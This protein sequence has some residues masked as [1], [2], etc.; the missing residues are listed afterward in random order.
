MKEIVKEKWLVI[1]IACSVFARVLMALYLGNTVVELPGTADQLSYHNLALRILDGHGFSFAETWW[2]LTGPDEPTAHWS[3]LYTL[4]VTAVYA[5]TGSNPVVAR[6]LQ[7]IIVGVLHP[8]LAY[9]IGRIIFNHSAG[10]I[11]AA[12]TAGYIYFIYYAGSLMTE[13][14][15][16]TAILGALYLLILMSRA[17]QSELKRL[18]VALG[19]VLGTVVLLRQLFLLLSPFLLLW[20][21]WA[22]FHKHRDF[23][24]Q[25]TAIVGV[26][27]M[28]MITP[29]TI[30]NYDR[31]GRFVLLNTNSGFAFFWGNH[32]IYGTQFEPILPRE[33]GSY[34]D[35]IPVELRHLS[36]PELE[37]ELLE[38]GL[39]F[40][41][42]DPVRYVRLSL[43]RIAPYFMFWPAADSSLISN[44]SRVLSFGLALPFMLGGL[45]LA[46]L[47]RPRSVASWLAAPSTLLLLFALLY[48]GIHVLT[49][50][51]IRYRLPV[52]AVII[53][54]AALAIQWVFGRMSTK[55]ISSE[56]VG[57]YIS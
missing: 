14:F 15:Y 13:P 41:F 30:Y 3:F 43:S 6:V 22:R 55:V 12:V 56:P 2:P 37:A 17:D 35:L 28:M 9:K 7:A 52:D 23:P 49:W 24:I 1:I 51:L 44:V 40:I 19:V 8:V 33:L 31:F 11:A 29:F 16:I 57:R 21:W 54:F 46:L 47:R 48:T 5:L 45:V 26:I 27:I 38:I 36:E 50:T 53:P 32:P 34:Q 20:L 10:L 39:G 42:D 18:A 4:Y 25:A